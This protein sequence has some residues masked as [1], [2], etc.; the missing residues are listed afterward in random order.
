MSQ[1]EWQP[2][3]GPGHL[4]LG[5]HIGFSEPLCPRDLGSSFRLWTA[6]SHDMLSYS[7][8]SRQGDFP[9]ALLR[10]P[11]YFS[12]VPLLRF[13]QEVPSAPQLRIE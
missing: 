6:V 1:T 8:S 12:L 2:S 3:R 10:G 7:D 11:S 5:F 13:F 4:H 9:L